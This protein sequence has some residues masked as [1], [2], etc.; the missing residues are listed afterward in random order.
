M[1]DGQ[2]YLTILATPH[3]MLPRIFTAHTEKLQTDLCPGKDRRRRPPVHFSFMTRL[4]I[5]GNKSTGR[6]DSQTQL[7]N[8]SLS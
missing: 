6:F 8:I 2:I 7:G 5:A 4:R 3:K 1:G